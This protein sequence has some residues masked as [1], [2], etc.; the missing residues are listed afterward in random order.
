MITCDLCERTSRLATN[1][2]VKINAEDNAIHTAFWRLD[3]C[4]ICFTK[5]RE[6]ITELLSK[7]HE[8]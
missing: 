3:I 1:A 4:L 5:I 7:K 8:E 6:K 2:T